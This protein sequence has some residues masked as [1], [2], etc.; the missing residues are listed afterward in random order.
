MSAAYY[1]A[2][3]GHFV[4]VIEA[5]PSAGGM[6][7]A[8]IPRYRLPREVIDREAG[9]IEDLGVEFQFNTRFGKDVTLDGLKKEGFFRRF[10]CNRRAHRSMSLRIENE[11]N[12]K[13]VIPAVDFLRNVALGDRRK[14]GDRVVVVGGGNVAI[15][16]ARTSFRLGAR[17]V[18]IAYRRTRH[19]MP[20]DVEEVGAG[21][22]RRGGF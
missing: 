4:R 7:L 15:D 8:G 5:L 19:E 16:A 17:Q 1:L 6:M 22:G 18:T 14:P 2:L 11:E 13:G 3:K 10:Y 9:M 12:L 20:A 21:R